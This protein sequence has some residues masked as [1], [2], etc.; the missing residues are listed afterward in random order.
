MTQRWTPDVVRG[1]NG[2]RLKHV[3]S[4]SR[5]MSTAHILRILLVPVFSGLSLHALTARGAGEETTEQRDVHAQAVELIPRLGHPQFAAREQATSQLIELGL[6][7]RRALEEARQHPDREIRYR[8]RRVLSIV[9]ELDFQRRLAAFAAGR[10]SD[11]HGLP[12]WELFREHYGAD[13][14]TRS[15]FVDMQKAEPEVMRAVEDGP[16]GTGK[17]IE[18]RCLELQQA[19]RVTRRQ[20]PLG[21]IVALLFAAAD[22]DVKLNFHSGSAI[23]SFCYQTS[24]TNAMNDPSKKPILSKMLGSWIK[25]SDGWTAYQSLSLAMRYGLKEGLIPAVKVLEQPGNQAYIRQNA[26]LAILKLGDESHMKLLESVL[27]DESRCTR[28]QIKNV[29]YETQLRDVA[30]VA[31]MLMRK[32]DPKKFGFD[33]LQTNT[34]NGFTTSTAGFASD[35]KRKAAFEKWKK[36]LAEEQQKAEDKRSVEDG[37]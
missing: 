34:S 19:Q 37:S 24:L 2:G 26:V 7:A 9:Q 10:S 3:P 31:I 27:D 35:D 32:Q 21:S 29:S 23:S 8:V 33:R 1:Y 36:F 28:Q 14:E 12:G 5:L 18:T 4:E 30:L 6:P 11:E 20:I 13:P 25:R 15:L 16:E 17:V 22:N